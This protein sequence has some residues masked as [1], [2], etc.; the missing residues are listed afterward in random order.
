LKSPNKEKDQLELFKNAIH[1]VRSPVSS[2]WDLAD[3]VLATKQ[4]SLD[5]QTCADIVEIQR[6]A[7]NLLAMIDAIGML[8]RIEIIQPSPVSMNLSGV[9]AEAIRRYDASQDANGRTVRVTLPSQLPLVHLAPELIAQAT[10]LL[11]CQC[12]YLTTQNAEIILSINVN[13]GFVT[14]SITAEHPTDVSS[15]GIWDLELLTVDRIM[16]QHQGRFWIEKCADQITGYHYSL[17]ADAA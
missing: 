17:P 14:V 8:I 11:I 5:K 10:F 4:E 16:A 12:S 13:D 7:Q 2:I 9:V 6:S 15:S 1:A 3:T